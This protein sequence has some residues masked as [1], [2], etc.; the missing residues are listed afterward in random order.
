MNSSEIAHLAESI[1]LLQNEAFWAVRPDSLGGKKGQQ[2]FQ[3]GGAMVTVAPGS[4]S[5]QRNRVLGLG[6]EERA[7]EQMVDQVL[8]IYRAFNVKRFSFHRSPCRQYGQ[9]GGWLEKRGFRPHHAYSKL[10]RE[11]TTA[12]RVQ[13][14]FQ[15]VR[16]GGKDAGAFVAVFRRVFPM[17]PKYLD[18]VGAAVGAPGFSHYLAFVGDRPVA[19]GVVYVKGN[20]AWMGWAGTLTD[21]RRRGAQSALI[22]TRIE[23]A[24]ELGAKW[25]FC[26]TM[27]PVRGRPA[28]SYRNLLKCG[29]SEAY[30]RPIW[31]WESGRRR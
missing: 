31:V 1:E 11:A 19:T 4:V 20:A 3:V 25:I 16:I 10:I 13:T 21:F 17:P 23:R 5:L 26:A 29:F 24:A 15:V 14:E 9:I 2:L 7:S 18:W 6:V 27:E 22:A 30:L 28:G 8:D 12:P